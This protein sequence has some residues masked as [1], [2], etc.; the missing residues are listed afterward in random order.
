M[1]PG[2]SADVKAIVNDLKLRNCEVVDNHM[3]TDID[4]RV[5]CKM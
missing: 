2:H 1:A 3:S 5:I 4:R